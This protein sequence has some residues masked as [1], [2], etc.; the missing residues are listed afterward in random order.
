MHESSPPPLRL[1]FALGILLV[2][3]SS[4]APTDTPPG[5]EDWTI[6]EDTIVF[7]S[8]R[9]GNYELYLMEVREDGSTGPARQITASESHHSWW[10]RISPTRSEIILH[11]TPSHLL[12]SQYTDA[13][14]I[15]V[16]TMSV[17][18]PEGRVLRRI[19]NRAAGSIDPSWS[20]DGETILFIG[21]RRQWCWPTDYEVFAVPSSNDYLDPLMSNVSPTRHTSDL[22]P[23]YDPYFDRDGR[24]AVWT[25]FKSLSDVDLRTG[26][27]EKGISHLLDD[28]HLSGMPQWSLD[29]EWIYFHRWVWGVS[30]PA[31][32]I[33]RI[34]PDGTDL[35]QLTFPE[36]HPGNNE[37]PSN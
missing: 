2:G 19:T 10:G 23:D 32:Q 3:T 26:D 31:W 12:P 28:D 36:T 7:N 16:W 13:F 20:P 37:F 21:C 1:A 30:E 8:N 11:R 35:T 17:A 4:A 33:F 27:P 14:W 18:D 25:T 5:D 22:M 6:P 29:G 9:G 34:R 15:S 24:S